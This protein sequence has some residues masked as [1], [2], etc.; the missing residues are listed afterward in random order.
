MA[1]VRG[2]REAFG[3]PG[4]EPRWTYA[5]KDG[6]GTAYST[7]SRIW[8]TLL[9]GIVT[10]V[11]CPTVDRAQIR[12]LQLLVT[13]GESFMHEERLNMHSQT[14]ALA[15]HVLGYR[16]INSDPSGRY[17][18]EKTILTDP[19]Y[20]SVLQRI[21]VKA[22][23][24]LRGKLKAFVLCAPHLDVA[25]WH[26]NAYVLDTQSRS[27][28]A[29]EKDGTWLVLDA[30][31]PFLKTSCGYV[32]RSDGWTDLADNF[33]LD[34]EFDRAVDGNVALIGE[35]DDPLR[36]FVVSLTF[37]NSI[38]NALTTLYGSL[39]TPFDQHEERFLEQWGR[40][41]HHLVPLEIQAQDGGKL[42]QSSFSL[43]LAHEDKAYPGAII[44]SMSIP[45]GGAKSD[46]DRGG[47]HLVWTRDLVNSVT[48]L[49]GAGNVES[50]RR[51]LIYLATSQRDDG[52]FPQ[53]MWI[54]GEPYWSG[55]QLDEVAFPIML[56][57]RMSHEEALSI[58]DP[59]PMVLRAAGYLM[60]HGPATAQER[61]EE[62]SGYSP[63]TLANNI[64]GLICAAAFA[65]EHGD[66]STALFIEDY[67]DYLDQHI[68]TWTVTTQGTLVP[69]IP[70]H[71]IR[72]LPVEVG[73]P[74]PAE[75]PNNGWLTLANVP[76]GQQYRYP[77]KDI[78]DGGFLELVRYGIRRPE[79]PIIVDS[80]RV[81]DK[82]LKV[83]TPLGPCWH[84]YNHD[85]YGERADG[86]P[87]ITYGI[88]RA[89]PLLTGER[90]HYELAAGR[91]VSL[92][93]KTL[94]HFASTTGL[95]S[96]QIWDE[97]SRP[98][99]KM[100]FGYPTGSA[101]PLMWAHAE[102]IKLLRSARDGRV[103]DRVPEAWSRYCEGRGS[104]KKRL[105][106]WK[107]RRQVTRMARD[108]T[109][110]VQ[111]PRPFRLHWTT[112]EWTTA[113]DEISRSTG[114][115]IDYVDVAIPKEAKGPVRF[116][117]FWNDTLEWEGHDYAVTIV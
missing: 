92:Y 78:V 72:I 19:H 37:G 107:R 73:D 51:A 36:E 81:I 116:T 101:R 10:E 111:I 60:R 7:P 2:P 40:S 27:L 52:G 16:V 69:G 31:R 34:W 109:L 45:W 105:Q 24:S 25:G 55:I 67:A 48:G 68:E 11:Y 103:F 115:G 98:S 20:P 80:V 56:A 22:D 106:I 30:S 94:E 93:I 79:D 26:N 53:N 102:Y 77:A 86:G 87:Y 49:L 1:S 43:L 100:E 70:R 91:E 44:A 112:D 64:A 46:E 4:I 82:I 65:R 90:G 47:Y 5:N 75:D 83:D 113:N 62:A 58:I 33:T 114:V 71:Y 28:L 12:D 84:R 88:G 23:E 8:F 21:V 97:P 104:Q 35:I 63:S 95:L 15:H 6:V 85:G 108:A 9:D 39:D 61:W 54:D 50:A 59:Y 99:M 117:F 57:R 13:D 110:R 17:S 74:T 3:A 42:F 66:E 18:I 96:E 14:E 41:R 32:G 38:H 89:W 29:A 76:P